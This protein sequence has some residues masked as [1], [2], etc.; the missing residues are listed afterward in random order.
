M[1]K[2]VSK[3]I[4]IFKGCRLMLFKY[5]EF[6]LWPGGARTWRNWQGRCHLAK[7][8]E[9]NIKETRV[10]REVLICPIWLKMLHFH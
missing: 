2:G 8:P 4:L 10:F 5:V 7:S 9:I 6:H 1:P 3:Y